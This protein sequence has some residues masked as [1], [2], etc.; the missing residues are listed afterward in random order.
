MTELVKRS[1]RSVAVSIAVAT[2]AAFIG[3][4]SAPRAA[5]AAPAVM[6]GYTC[7][8][9]DVCMPGSAACCFEVIQTPPGEG[10]CSTMC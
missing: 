1:F 8:Y 9:Y 4:A 5:V 10:R 7:Y 6:D 2:S 3:I